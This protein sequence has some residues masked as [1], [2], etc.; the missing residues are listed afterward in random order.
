[1]KYA[2]AWAGQP[3]QFVAGF[4]AQDLELE[5]L[6]DAVSLVRGGCYTT[7][8][9]EVLSL[10]EGDQDKPAARKTRRTPQGEE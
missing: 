7:T 8:D 3:G 5:S 10:V 1:M 2:L 6:E 4:P 9:R